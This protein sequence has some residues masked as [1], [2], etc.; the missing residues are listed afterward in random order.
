MPKLRAEERSAAGGEVDLPLLESRNSL[1]QRLLETARQAA[2]S[3]AT[4]LLIGES[5]TG[6][7]VLARQIH[8][9]SRR[10]EGAFVVVNCTTLSSHLLENELFGHTRG[11]FTGAFEDKPGRLETAD[12]G[13]VFL[14]EI[15]GLVPE[16]QTKFLRFVQEQ[17]FERLGGDSTI[18]VN[19]RLI[20]SSNRDLMAEVAAHRFRED[21]FYR[22]NVI[23]L[24]VPP[25]RERRADILPLAERLLSSATLRRRGEPV[26][27][28]REA[29]SAIKLYHWPGNVR[30]LRN[31]LER[32]VVLTPGNVITP[33]CLPDALL[34][35]PP[36][37]SNLSPAA[38][39]DKLER[40]HII[41]VL[42]ETPTLEHAAARLG[43]DP[44]TLWRKRKRYKID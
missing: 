1:M 8:K 15:A 43:I 42:A 40:E 11:A 37:A 9:W 31:A 17:T 6:K 33:E 28:S 23:T 25:L 7:N 26:H 4:I 32:A 39:L 18:Q 14:D 5:G 13:T 38:N 16:L 24:Q 22:L 27:L 35:N 2:A 3:E 44:S 36:E 19:T 21:L 34:R 12:G 29:A 20:A 10:S 41:Q 30:E